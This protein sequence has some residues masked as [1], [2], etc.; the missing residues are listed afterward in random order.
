VLCLFIFVDR[1]A[2][3]LPVRALVTASAAA[4]MLIAAVSIL[5][6]EQFPKISEDVLRFPMEAFNRVV[7][8]PAAVYLDQFNLIAFFIYHH[9]WK[10]S[11]LERQPIPGIDIYR[12]SRGD[13]RM[14]VF[15]DKGEWNVKPVDASVYNKLAECLQSGETSEVSIFDAFQTPPEPGSADFKLMRR[16]VISLAS[17]SAVCAQR[18]SVNSIGWFATFRKTGCS[19]VEFKPPRKTG[20]FDDTSA[21]IEYGGLWRHDSLAAAA[22][23]TLSF[24]NEPASSASLLFRGTGI[25]WFYAKAFNR[26]IASIKID[27]VPREDVDLYSPKIAWQSRT[28][29]EGLAEG[30]HTFEVT[31]SGRKAAAATDRFVDVDA[32]VVH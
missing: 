8:E 14:V 24:S 29:F 15:R 2:A 21:E 11:A 23:G 9:D 18:L 26:G 12:L 1:L 7:P 32:F 10:W 17:D 20:T 16:T 19:A 4:A 6:F 3:L 13:Q 5:R 22:G 31:V 30:N 28:S 27:G 25:T